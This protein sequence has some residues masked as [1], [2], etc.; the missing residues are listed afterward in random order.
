VSVQETSLPTV[1]VSREVAW[2]MVPSVPCMENWKIPLVAL[3]AVTVNV[4]P[5]GVGT[6]EGGEI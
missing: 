3:P 4:A 2:V 6:K 1:S 5:E